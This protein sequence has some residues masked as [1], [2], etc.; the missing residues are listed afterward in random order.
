MTFL[1]KSNFH[2]DNYSLLYL[3][4]EK[5]QTTSMN[6]AT[7]VLQKKNINCNKRLKDQKLSKEE[8]SH[9]EYFSMFTLFTHLTL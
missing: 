7:I 6:I 4:I 8:K 5:V 3:M 9:L 2:A 1:R